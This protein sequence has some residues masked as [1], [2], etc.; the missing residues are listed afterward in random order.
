MKKY[1]SVEEANE[2]LPWLE[3]E[4]TY[5]QELKTEFQTKLKELHTYKHEHKSQAMTSEYQ[6][7]V[8]KMECGLEFMEVE[9]K[10]RIQA[11]YDRGIQVK[12]ID[13]G[14]VDFP[15]VVNGEEVLLCWRLGE[16]AITHYHGINEGFAGR[17]ELF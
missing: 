17:K 1:F 10:N 12:Q 13:Y 3:R 11:L 14:L 8:F 15:S 5:L 2:L 6:D 4:I 9:A 16:S 7:A